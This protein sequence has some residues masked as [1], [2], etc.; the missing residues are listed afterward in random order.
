MYCHT[1]PHPSPFALISSHFPYFFPFLFYCY[2]YSYDDDH[3]YYYYYYT[4]FTING[5]GAG[6]GKIYA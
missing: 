4:V 1:R 5:V 3:N 6:H 2:Y